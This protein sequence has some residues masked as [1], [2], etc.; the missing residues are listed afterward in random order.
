MRLGEEEDEDEEAFE[1]NEDVIYG[2]V[3][4]VAV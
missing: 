1:V 2:G 4:T 3:A